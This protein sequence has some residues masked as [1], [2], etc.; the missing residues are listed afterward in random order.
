M[1]MHRGSSKGPRGPSRAPGTLPLSA[2]PRRVAVVLEVTRGG[3]VERHR[4]RVPVGTL[5]RAVLREIGRAPEGCAVLRDDASV[6]LDTPIV[7]PTR[8]VVVPTFSGG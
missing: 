3:A 1:R 6:P 5:V 4:L 7:A 2:S 8:F